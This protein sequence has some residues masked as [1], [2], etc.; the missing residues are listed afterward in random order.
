MMSLEEIRLAMTATLFLIGVV[1]SISGLWIIMAKEYH[2]AMRQLSAQSIRINGRAV[3][4]DAVAPV[5]DSAARLVEAISQL[6]R[7]AAGIGAFL[8][9]VGVG[10]CVIAF[11]L[12]TRL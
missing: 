8:C 3:T 9:V 1:A 6:I 5:I 7:T 11:W 4:Q 10:I 2:S 12:T